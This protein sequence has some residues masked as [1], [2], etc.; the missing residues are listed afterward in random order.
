MT[1]ILIIALVL[2]AACG[3]ASG[4]A[5]ATNGS[6]AAAAKPDSLTRRQKDSILANSRVPGAA[7][8]RSAM[9]VADSTSAHINALDTVGQ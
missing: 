4:N 3:G 6:A 1:R 7:G 5:S 8:V 9:K 2:A